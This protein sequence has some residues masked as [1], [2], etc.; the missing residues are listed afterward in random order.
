MGEDCQLDNSIYKSL[1]HLLRKRP[2]VSLQ[3]S[4]LLKF[5]NLLLFS[6]L[7]FTIDSLSSSKFPRADIDIRLF[8]LTIGRNPRYCIHCQRRRTMLTFETLDSKCF[9]WWTLWEVIMAIIKEERLLQWALCEQVLAAGWRVLRKWSLCGSCSGFR[10]DDDDVDSVSMDCWL[11]R[12]VHFFF[13]LHW[14]RMGNPLH[15]KPG[16]NSVEIAWFC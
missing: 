14:V 3:W 4:Y 8:F 12:R 15:H 16:E 11:V 1:I 9:H 13:L 7:F 2:T 5:E 10:K 6:V